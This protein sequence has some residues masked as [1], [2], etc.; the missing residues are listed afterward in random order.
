M[1]VI[2]TLR[3]EYKEQKVELK[4]A[5][6]ARVLARQQAAADGESQ[7][8]ETRQQQ[9][10]T[11]QAARKSRP[12]RPVRAPLVD[13]TRPYR[14]AMLNRLTQPTDQ[15]PDDKTLPE[16]PGAVGELTSGHK[17]DWRTGGIQFPRVS[18]V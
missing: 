2:A 10:V 9:V 3:T 17:I 13:T 7:A 5:H 6:D 1:Q 16:Y 12:P 11:A 8:D 14:E 15:Q 4:Q 18:L